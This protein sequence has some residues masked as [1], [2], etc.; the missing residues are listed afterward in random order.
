MPGAIVRID[1]HDGTLVSVAG[2]LVGASEGE[3]LHMATYTSCRLMHDPWI[4]RTKVIFSGFEL[5]NN[6]LEL[7]DLLV[8]FGHLDEVVFVVAEGV[9]LSPILSLLELPVS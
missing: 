9:G 5:L 6:L 2:S 4:V 3:A 8:F 1:I 7:L